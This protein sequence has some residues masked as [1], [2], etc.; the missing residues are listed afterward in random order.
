M[1]KC[2]ILFSSLDLNIRQGPNSSILIEG[3][4]N[5]SNVRKECHNIHWLC[6][7]YTLSFLPGTVCNTLLSLPSGLKAAVQQDPLQNGILHK[8]KTSR[9]GNLKRHLSLNELQGLSNDASKRRHSTDIN[10]VDPFN[11]HQQN[12]LNIKNNI[13]QGNS[14]SNS[15]NTSHQQTT[16]LK[17]LTTTTRNTLDVSVIDEFLSS[18]SNSPGSNIIDNTLL[19]SIDLTKVNTAKKPSN[20]SLP[21]GQSLNDLIASSNLTLSA[22]AVTIN[23][24]ATSSSFVNHQQ[25]ASMSISSSKL[26]NKLISAA[27]NITIT[28]GMIVS[29]PNAATVLRSNTVRSNP[30]T[31][32]NS[33]SSNLTLKQV[34]VNFYWLD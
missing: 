28:Q 26:S 33:S 27:P 19:T 31:L 29:L 30:E 34:I 17:N 3:T 11:N 6:G 4:N 32:I 21:L 16:R 12:N 7:N 15:S 8:Q 13:Q 1:Y 25:N 9:K 14:D 18:S 5:S 22:P 10:I 20:S 23:Q 24:G 2:I